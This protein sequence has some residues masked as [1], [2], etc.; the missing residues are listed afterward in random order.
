[1]IEYLVLIFGFL[2]LIGLKYFLVNRTFENK[3]NLYQNPEELARELCSKKDKNIK[4]VLQEV[5]DVKNIL[6]IIMNSLAIIS[7]ECNS[8]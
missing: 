7:K 4:K 6:N 8:G 5:F 2:A 3:K 1:M